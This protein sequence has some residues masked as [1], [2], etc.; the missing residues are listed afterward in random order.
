MAALMKQRVLYIFTHD[1]IGV[2]EDGPTHQPVEH[3]ASL[4]LIPNLDVWRPADALESAVA[5][6]CGIERSDGPTMLCLSRQNL[7]VIK[8]DASHEARVRKGGYVLADADDAQ[9]TLIATGS[10]VGLALAAKEKLAAEGVRARVVS[11][12][13][14]QRFDA[15]SDEYKRSVLT[16][17]MPRLAIEAGSPDGWWKYL[18]GAP[19]ADVIGMTTFGESAPAG[20]LMKHFGFT[21]EHVVARAKALI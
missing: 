7:A 2:G 18:A 11:M 1:S 5:Y 4:R 6:A 12:P 10:E 3:V 19:K 8:R 14:T 21:V 16:S 9:I 20:V 15:Q 17:R 13:C